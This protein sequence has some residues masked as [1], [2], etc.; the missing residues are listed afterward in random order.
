MKIIY[1]VICI[2][3]LASCASFPEHLTVKPP[4]IIPDY[5]EISNWAA[6][7][8]KEDPADRM[9]RSSDPVLSFSEDVDVFFIHPTTYYN[10]G[11]TNWNASINNQEL[12]TKTDESTILFQASAFNGAGR[13][14][15]PRYR[16]A[17][18][19]AFYTDDRERGEKAL[20]AAYNDVKNAFIHF[21]TNEN[22]GRPIIIASHSQGTRHAKVLL[23]E[24]FDTNEELRSRLVAAY[25]IGIPVLKDQFAH[26]KPCLR[27]ND[28]QCFVSWRTF[29]NG[30]DPKEFPRNENISVINPLSWSTN[31]EYVHSDKN[32]GTILRNFH[33]VYTNLVDARATNDGL[34]FAH[35][36][37]FP[38]SFLMTRSNY[39]IADIN[40]YYYNVRD[41]AIARVRRFRNN[42]ENEIAE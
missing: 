29:K 41:N 2:I 36:P 23:A 28:I 6:H 14:Y 20:D 19:E 11:A 27:E 15:A 13:V 26:I 18:L 40:F 32:K 21:L 12:N 31:T 7:P 22:K 39:H 35:K 24:F 9:P 8:K 10:R 42:D 16:Q 17:H 4:G 25:L 37:K 38:W 30:Y 33:K 3:L 1:S 5:S 34:L